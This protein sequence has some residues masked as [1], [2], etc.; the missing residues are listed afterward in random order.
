MQLILAS[1]SPRRKELL[2][3]IT[4]N[5]DVCSADI[6]ETCLANESAIDY[7]T[8]LAEEKAAVVKQHYPDSAVIGSDTAV[9]IE[10]NILGKPEN[11]EDSLRILRLLSGKVHQVMTA[12]CVMTATQKTTRLVVTDVKFKTLTDEEIND[13]WLTGE[14]QDKAGSYAI[15]GI[16]GKF[17]ESI[18]GS[19]SSVIGLPLVELEQTLKEVLT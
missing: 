1:Q 9:V 15:Q 7:V 4:S 2:S 10:Q 19:V 12:F 14:P 6:D 8:R 18:N 11:L 3:Y 17:V 16:G 5:F 13:Y